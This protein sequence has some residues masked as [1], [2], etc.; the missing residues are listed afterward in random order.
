M[1]RLRWGRTPVGRA[2]VSGSDEK[3]RARQG[4][5]TEA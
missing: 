5:G 2:W 4:A 3:D 1:R